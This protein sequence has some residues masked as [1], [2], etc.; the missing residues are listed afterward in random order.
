MR[1][2]SLL[3]I[4]LST[5]ALAS[6]YE[7]EEDLAPASPQPV[8][9]A[10]LSS[11]QA[12]RKELQARIKYPDLFRKRDDGASTSPTSDC[13]TATSTL[14]KRGIAYNDFEVVLGPQHMAEFL[15]KGGQFDWPNGTSYTDDHYIARF[16]TPSDHKGWYHHTYNVVKN[17]VG[18]KLFEASIPR[19]KKW[20]AGLK[21]NEIIHLSPNTA[22]R[23]QNIDKLEKTL[24]DNPEFKEIQVNGFRISRRF[25]EAAN[26]Y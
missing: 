19:Y 24:L 8:S 10:A 12:N 20:K 3:L 26:A 5:C 9:R 17:A 2:Y 21:H 6:S 11:R 7:A 22:I 4:V 25:F 23:S 1:F 14:R 13:A 16:N 15:L 18:D